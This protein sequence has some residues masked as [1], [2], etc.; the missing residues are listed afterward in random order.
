MFWDQF[1]EYDSQWLQSTTATKQRAGTQLTT[2]NVESGI[3]D[4]R[5]VTGH[6][7]ARADSMLPV[8]ATKYSWNTIADVGYQ[9][10]HYTGKLWDRNKCVAKRKKEVDQMEV[11]SVIRRGKKSE[12]VDGT[13]VRLA[14]IPSEKGDLVRWRFVSI[15]VN[16]HERYDGFADA[17]ALKLFPMSM[18]R[19]ASQRHTVHCHRKITA[20]LDATTAWFHK[21]MDQ[22]IH[23][24]PPRETEPDSSVVWLLF[25][26]HSGAK[27][28]ARTNVAGVFSQ[29]STRDRWM[30][31]RS[32]GAK[33]V[34]QSRGL[35]QRRRCKHV[36]AQGQSVGNL[37]TEAKIVRQV[38][39]WKL[40]GT[41]S[42]R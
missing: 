25:K 19:A 36:W 5:S 31:R 15:E 23:A 18:A 37:G 14:A 21:D 10:E 40:A 13:H 11:F 3:G 39:S 22:L 41:T 2:N 28:A 17:Q 12:A 1:K 9:Y 32:D 20:I 33:C 7:A 16:Q 24:H 4:L 29:R 27:R 34:P 8:E 35:E 38:S 6:Q 30:E 42:I 26:S